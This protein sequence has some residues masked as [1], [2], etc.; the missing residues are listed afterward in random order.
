MKKYPYSY[1]HIVSGNITELEKPHPLDNIK[2]KSIFIEYLLKDL[3]IT[4]VEEISNGKKN[5]FKIYYKNLYYNIFIEFPDGG[6]KDISYNSTSKKIAIPYHTTAFKKIINNYERV[7]VINIYVPLDDNGNP[8]FSKKVYLIVDPKQI[9]LSNV[10]KKE[11]YNSSSRWVKLEEILDVINNKIYKYN[12]K[13]NVYI[14]Y[15]EKLEWFFNDILK[16]EYIAMIN[17]ELSNIP[18]SDLTDENNKKYNKYR[19]LFREMLISN[20][21]IECEIINCRINI[22]EL[23]VAS[24]IKPVNKI[25]ND[26]SLDKLQKITEISDPNNGFLL[27]P[28]H[29]GL[30]DK[31][32]ITFNSN[33]IL[34]ISRS[35]VGQIS[36]F[37]L[38]N[39][40]KVINISGREMI[41]YLEFHN[42][43]FNFREQ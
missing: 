3:K 33:G 4:N 10:I 23:M 43:E 36:Y 28:N 15:W 19:R 42:K 13:K 26:K 40:T 6:G 41:K 7:L 24:H 20:R 18:L 32:L 16:K 37:N 17:S 38:V 8:D 39:E 9:Y 34:K 30:F 21:G 14:V 1:K 11:T 12:N 2:D 35:I 25:I 31:F 22:L 5:L 27:C 29:D